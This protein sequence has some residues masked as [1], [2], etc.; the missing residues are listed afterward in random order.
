MTTLP[1]G[2]TGFTAM[3]PVLFTVSMTTAQTSFRLI[4]LTHPVLP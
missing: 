3:P 2:T 4:L 1:G